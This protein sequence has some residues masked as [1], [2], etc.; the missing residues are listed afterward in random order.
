MPTADLL[1]GNKTESFY[2]RS[3][4]AV[5]PA[6]G[7]VAEAMVALVLADAALEKFGGD[8]IGE[9]KRNFK[10]FESTVGPREQIEQDSIESAKADAA[11]DDGGED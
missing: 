7:V 5:V 1:T 2:E 11:E 10:S 3:D 8:H 9:L 6:G 4:V